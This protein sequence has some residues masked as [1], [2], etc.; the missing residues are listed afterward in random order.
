VLIY[1]DRKNEL[2]QGSEEL[3]AFLIPKRCT[4]LLARVLLV[5]ADLKCVITP[6]RLVI[7]NVKDYSISSRHIWKMLLHELLTSKKI[8]KAIIES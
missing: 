7:T 4:T 5:I 6:D 2:R 8:P 1:R 3:A